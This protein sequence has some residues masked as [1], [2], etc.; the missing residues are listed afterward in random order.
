MG[1]NTLFPFSALV[2]ALPAM[3]YPT[4]V[5]TP[6]YRSICGLLVVSTAL[7]AGVLLVVAIAVFVREWRTLQIIL[8]FV[9][10]PMLAAPWIL[11]ESY[12]WLYS[13]VLNSEKFAARVTTASPVTYDLEKRVLSSNRRRYEEKICLFI[14]IYVL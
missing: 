11:P 5:L 3:V 10:V 9:P 1:F 6:R 14:L 4:E 13:K 2:L 12:R 7:G 8:T